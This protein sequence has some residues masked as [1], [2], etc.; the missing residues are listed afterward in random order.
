MHSRVGGTW[1]DNSKTERRSEKVQGGQFKPGQGGGGQQD[2][3]LDMD[4]WGQHKP[5][6]GDAERL[7]MNIRGGDDRYQEKQNDSYLA[8]L[9]PDGYF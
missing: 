9:D 3:Q 2:G 5:G 1:V 6:R 8:K 7:T 4:G